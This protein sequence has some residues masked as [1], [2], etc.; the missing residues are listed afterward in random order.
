MGTLCFMEG[1]QYDPAGHAFYR[2]SLGLQYEE[3]IGLLA[4]RHNVILSMRTL[5]RRLASYGLYR[6]KN[7][8]DV[9]QVAMFIFEQLKSSSCLHGYRWMHSRCLQNGLIVQKEMVRILLGILD[10]SGV[11]ARVKRKLKEGTIDPRVPTTYGT[12]THM[13]S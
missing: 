10:P 6:R 2:L 8:S 12:L 3:I 1:G 4:Q 11:A 9:L 5:K 13:I 7:F